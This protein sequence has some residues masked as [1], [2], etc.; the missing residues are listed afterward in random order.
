MY[1]LLRYSIHDSYTS[2]L[3][4]KVFYLTR[5]PIRTCLPISW[6]SDV[7]TEVFFNI[8]RLLENFASLR[9]WEGRKAILGLDSAPCLLLS[10]L[11]LGWSGLQTD[12]ACNKGSHSLSKCSE[13]AACRWPLPLQGRACRRCLHPSFGAPSS[14]A[15]L[16]SHIRRCTKCPRFTTYLRWSCHGLAAFLALLILFFI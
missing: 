15:R 1:I 7:K 13:V 4:G 2:W 11:A 10:L 12:Q 6:V 3:L 16:E 5:K 9:K 14:H 8:F